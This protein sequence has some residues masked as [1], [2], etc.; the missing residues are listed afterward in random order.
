MDLIDRYVNEVGVHLPANLRADVEAELRSLLTDSLDER[1]RSA[2]RAPDDALAADVLRAFG[3]PRDVAARY[4]P[5]ARYL[6]GPGL[7]PGYVIAVKI[8]VAAIAVVTL[9]LMALGRYHHEGDLS[10]VQPL[11]RAAGSFLSGTFF[12]LSLLTLAFAIV[13]RAMQTRGQTGQQWDP[14]KLPPVNDPDRVSYFGRVFMLWALAAVVLL[15]NVFPPWVAIVM[16]HNTE[17]RTI[18]LLLPAF[19]RYLPILNVFWAA[20]FVL[21]LVVLRH[22]RWRPSTRW[23]DLGLTVLNA[24]VLVVIITGPPVFEYD[25]QVKGVLGGTALFIAIDCVARLFRLLRRG[26]TAAPFAA[27]LQS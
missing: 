3:R 8:M 19:S 23:A 13:E 12:N 7:Y 15:F 16:I 27:G 10:M 6:V 1:A 4:A 9:V 14:A 26:R 20:A 22:G 18:P 17:V 24:V 2:G 21:N 25:P 11:I 5:Q